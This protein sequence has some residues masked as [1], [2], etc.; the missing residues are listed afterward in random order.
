MTITKIER[1]KKNPQRV[2]IFLDGE[3]AF[4][5]H[6]AVLLRW[7]LRTGDVLPDDRKVQLMAEE[8][9]H[10]ARL[11]ALRLLHA[12]LRTEKEL[13]DKL[14][15]REYGT[16]VI[17]SVVT[18]LRENGILDDTRFAEAFLH[19][20]QLRNDSGPRLLRQE[21]RKRGVPLPVVDR[22]LSHSSPAEQFERAL[23]TARGYIKKTP[24]IRAEPVALKQQQSLGR[25][26]LR[27]GF[28]WTTIASVLKKIFGNNALG[29]EEE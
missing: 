22:L 16:T 7:G 11:D 21:M 29:S 10:R 4:G 8:E 1:Q 17:D 9:I 13:R 20:R 14:R 12:R 24:R 18:A 3:F 2:N 5:V 25:Y 26:L 27:R 28:E 19:D 15:D 23:R 6:R